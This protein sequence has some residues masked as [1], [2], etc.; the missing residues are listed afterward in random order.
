MIAKGKVFASLH[1][2]LEPVIV[3]VLEGVDERRWDVS[4]WNKKVYLGA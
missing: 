4:E 3:G 2:H 1:R